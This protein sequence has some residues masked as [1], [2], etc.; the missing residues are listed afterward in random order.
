MTQ[1]VVHNS[2]NGTLDLVD[3]AGIQRSVIAGSSLT[4]DLSPSGYNTAVAN[5]GVANVTLVGVTEFEY[6]VLGLTPVATPTD[7]L[8]IQGSATQVVRIKRIKIGGVATAQGNMPAQLIRRLAAGGTQGSAVLTA[9]A[10]GKH[11]NNDPSATA[12]VSTIGTANFT[13]VQTAVST[14]K[15]GRVS[16]PASGTGAAGDASTLTWD[17]DE[18]SNEPI[19]LRG[20]SD[21]LAINLN[22]AAV[23]SGGVLDFQ[24]ETQES[25]T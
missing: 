15:V 10:A 16:M 3:S 25:S 21:Y 8:L 17:F 24:I 6:A 1:Y 2:Q 19:V 22:G 14:L 13:T 12:V 4:I 7:V 23:P 5:V 9:V 18:D 11:D 20:V